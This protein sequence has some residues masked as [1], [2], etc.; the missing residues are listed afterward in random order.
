MRRKHFYSVLAPVFIL[1]VLIG[2]SAVTLQRLR[3]SP[4]DKAYH[5]TEKQAEFIRLGLKVGV[6]RVDIAADGTVSVTFTIADDKG[7]PLDRDGLLTPGPVSLGFVLARIPRGETQYVSYTTRVRRNPTTGISYLQATTDSGGRFE[8]LQDATYRYTF[9]TKLPADFDRSVT[10]TLGVQANRNLTEWDLG[11]SVDNPVFHFVPDGSTVRTVRDVVRTEACNSQCHDPLKAHGAP[12]G[13]R[14]EVQLCVLCHTPQ[15]TDDVTGNPVDLKVMVHKIHRG[16]DLPSVRA[17]NRYQIEDED[18]STVRLPQ[19]IRNCACHAQSQK[20]AQANNYLERPSRAACGSCH[21]DVNFAT[22]HGQIVGPLAD[23][24][25]C[26]TCHVPD[27][28]KE[29][30][31]SVKGAHTVP[32]K[33]RQLAGINVKIIEFANTGPGQNLVVRYTLTN[34]AG[35]P[36]LPSDLGSLLLVLSGPTTDYRTRFSEDARADSV[37]L[38]D[39]S[40]TYQFKSAIPD[41]ATGT[42]AAGAAAFRVVKLNPATTQEI[43]FRETARDHSVVYF[44]VTDPQ[45]VK[46]R[47]VVKRERCNACHENLSL[48]GATRHDPEFCIMC[49]RPGQTDADRRP[50]DKLPVQGIHFK[51][52]IHRIHSGEEMT[53]DF[54]VYGF[55]NTPF[56]FNEVRFPGDRRNCG[57]CHEGNS[58]EV[59]TKGI[60][61][62]VAPREFYNPI[63]ANAAACLA[64]H[65]TLDAA[66]HAY[67]MTTPFGEACG[68]CHGANAE[69][70]VA[71]VHAR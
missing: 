20:A 45:P 63:P 11:Y 9:G 49:H 12:I 47:I 53:R 3:Y 15:T 10:H 24:S 37:T 62:T 54:T 67:A 18:F 40:Y 56:N 2:L 32:Y 4:F 33:S 61:P 58:Y 7:L 34:N 52:L 14:R 30:D 35:Q 51:F 21:D 8:K 59:P 70:A 36:I 50:A 38:S 57:K 68:A 42:F 22:G 19:D 48:H 55:G 64:C 60:L 28:G 71:K 16:A 69:F 1:T 65:D 39:G 5:L 46:R 44:G 17:G 41:D 25:L 23:D 43:D 26:S 13:T 27:T 31:V 6:R 29:F 66:A